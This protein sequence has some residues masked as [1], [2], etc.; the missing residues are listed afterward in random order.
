MAETG[1]EGR[2]RPRRLERLPGA[3]LRRAARPR[4]AAA[5]A[6]G[7]PPRRRP[8]PRQP[9]GRARPPHVVEALRAR[10]PRGPD[11][12]GY[13]PFR[14]LPRLREAIAAPLPRP[15]YGVELDPEREVAVVPGDEDG[16]RRARARARPSAATRSCSPTRT[17]PTTPRGSRSPAPSSASC[18]S[19]RPRAGSPTSTPR[20]PAA[21]LYLN[22]PSNPCAVCA[23]P[24]TLRGGGR[25]RRSARAAA[26]VHDAAYIDLVFDGRAPASFLAT[27]GAKEVGV[28]LWT[29]SKTLRHGR[30]A[31]RLRRRQRG[32]R[33]AHQPDRATTRASACFAAL[34]HAAIAALEG[35]AGQRRGAARDVRAAARPARRR[36]CP[37]RRSARAPSTSGCGCP[38]GLT[39]ERLLAEH[40]VA[41][42]PGEGFGPSGAGWARLSLAVTDEVL[43]AGIERLAPVL[44]AAVRV[45]IGIVVPF[46]WSYWGG[47]VEHAENQ[48]AAL[49]DRGHEV[50]ILMGH[51]PPGT[52]DAP[53]PP[54]HRPP[55]RPAAG[56]H[57][58]RPLGRRARRTARCRTSSSRR[59][60]SRRDPRGR[61]TSERFD[62]VHLHEPMTPA[63][64]VADAR[65]REVPA[66]RHL[67]RRRRAR[68]DARRDPD[69]GVPDRADRRADR[70]LADGGRVGGAV[71]RARVRDRPERRRR[72]GARRSGR[73][74]APGRL[75][76]PPRHAQ[77]AAGAAARVARDPPRAPAPA[78]A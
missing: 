56:D 28:E 19:T 11:V 53:A 66:R 52:A 46:S 35:P 40:R 26:I 45:K 71:A 24:G 76:R 13:A 22:Y 18:R 37:S 64:C 58:G 44:A 20:P 42:A 54:A 50:K 30:L 57:P 14:G 75:H 15:S 63:I 49:R 60:R 29:M 78:C 47:V 3:V 72:P 23:A 73:P 6:D 39:P 5:A 74:R 4:I 77:G 62:V 55:R 33:R 70:R 67:A 12:H 61:S 7:G 65:V 51:D 25:V 68:L 21:A 17:T 32:D 27:P 38:S 16:D 34:Q 9:R 10:R 1:G 59:G 8:R 41:L 48:A 2:P 69:V 31:D 36:R 43:D